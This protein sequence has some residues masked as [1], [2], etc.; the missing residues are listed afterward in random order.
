MERLREIISLS[1]LFPGTAR[2]GLQVTEA[3]LLN[4]FSRCKGHDVTEVLSP[5][6]FTETE[7]NLETPQQDC[8][9]LDLESNP[10]PLENED[11]NASHCTS[12]LPLFLANI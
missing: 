7:I 3:Y 1:R 2:M 6:S 11:G 10:V 5:H 4:R 9:P 8:L 12:L